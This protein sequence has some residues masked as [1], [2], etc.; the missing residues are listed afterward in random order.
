MTKLISIN[1]AVKLG[2]RR[3]RKP[4]WLSPLDY[5]EIDIIDGQLGPWI[6][7]YSPYISLPNGNDYLQVLLIEN[8]VPLDT[9]EYTPYTMSPSDEDA[10]RVAMEEFRLLVSD[11]NTED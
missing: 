4:E 9:K 10:F 3:L 7:L 11:T 2:H 6:R 5:I 1:E 8:N